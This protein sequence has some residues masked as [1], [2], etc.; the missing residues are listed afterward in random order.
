V[1]FAF[2]LR[3]REFAPELLLARTGRSR[4]LFLPR[5][6]LAR[7]LSSQLLFDLVRDDLREGNLAAAMGTL[8]RIGHGCSLRF[9]GIRAGAKRYCAH[10]T[11]PG[12]APSAVGRAQQPRAWRIAFAAAIQAFEWALVIGP[13]GAVFAWTSVMN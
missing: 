12:A 8:D 11:V 5:G 7:E 13:L 3:L 2:C 9:R 10:R 6:Q 4:E 1:L